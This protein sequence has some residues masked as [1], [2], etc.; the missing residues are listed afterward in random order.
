NEVVLLCTVD[1]EYRKRGVMHAVSRGLTAAA[2]IVGAPANPRPVIAHKGAVRWRLTP[3]GRAAHTSRPEQGS[4]AIY[5]MVEVIEHL[6]E[7]IEP[8]LA[9]ATD[10]LLDPPRLTV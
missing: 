7:R 10:P 5:E 9:Q 4:N 1:E 2:A 8:A 6:R 3:L